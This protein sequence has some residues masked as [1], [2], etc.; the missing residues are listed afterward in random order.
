MVNFVH[1]CV[2]QLFFIHL[3]RCTWSKSKNHTLL[4]SRG[5]IAL[6]FCEAHDFENNVQKLWFTLWYSVI[7]PSTMPPHFSTL[8]AISITLS[9]WNFTV[10][11]WL[12]VIEIIG[13]GP[14][15]MHLI[16]TPSIAVAFSVDSLISILLS[17][18]PAKETVGRIFNQSPIKNTF[19]WSSSFLW[20][21]K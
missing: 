3:R 8:M 1:F 17:L 16:S 5:C 4:T 20:N 15:C 10:N 7:E 6:N 19:F 2:I 21:S 13:L 11:L 18:S 14:L 12:G 9:Y